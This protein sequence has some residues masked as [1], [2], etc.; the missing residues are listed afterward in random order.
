MKNSWIAACMATA[1]AFAGTTL[2]AQ[3]PDQA[4]RAT[5]EKLRAD[6]N[7]NHAAYKA[8]S[9]KFYKVVDEVVVPRFDVPY[10]AQIIL[11]REWKSASEAQRKRF[12]AAFK[13]SLVHSYASALLDYHDSI[14]EEW[15][16]LRMSAGAKE[17]T[18]KVNILRENAQ[19]LEIA[20]QTHLTGNEWKV[21]D[22]NVEGVSLASGFR[23]QFAGEIKKTGLDGLIK[24]L[25][26]GDKPLLD[27][28]V[29]TG[30]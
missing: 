4:V 17:A 28:P 9:A 22:V 7:K 1:L 18:V 27:K 16:P 20:F 30:G 26:G 23:A 14:K 13:N 21:Y 11:G 15:Q 10:I 25:E 2:A 8:D 29:A 3:A 5:T 6:I 19:P 12:I 24:R